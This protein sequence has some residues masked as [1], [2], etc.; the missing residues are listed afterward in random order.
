M[1]LPGGEIFEDASSEER[2][3][4]ILLRWAVPDEGVDARLL[5]RDL[6]ELPDHLLEFRRR[7]G[8]GGRQG[9]A[10]EFA[11]PVSE[12]RQGRHRAP[13]PVSGGYVH[14]AADA[15]IDGGASRVREH[16]DRLTVQDRVQDSARAPA[17][18]W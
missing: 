1:L 8:T 6:L 5:P 14:A 16:V 18:H 11:Q 9:L 2:R 7:G 17:L 10:G 4:D 12:G 13:P 15:L 3:L